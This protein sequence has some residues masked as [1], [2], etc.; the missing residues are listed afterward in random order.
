MSILVLVES[1]TKCGKIEEYLGDDYKC[2]ATFGHL[3]TLNHLDDINTKDFSI[4]FTIDETKRKQINKIKEAIQSCKD[5]IIAT[6]GDREGEGIAWHICM[7]FH[8]PLST[9]KRVVFNEITKK[10]INESFQNIKTIDMNLVYAQQARQIIDI[11]VGFSLSPLLWKHV[12][13]SK[14]G[15]SAGRCQTPALKIIYDNQKEIDHSSGEF[16]YNTVGYF[17]SLNIPYHLNISFKDS[18]EIKTFLDNCKTEKYMLHNKESKMIFKKS[19]N[20]FTTSSLQQRCCKEMR[21]SPKETMTICQ[22]L[23]E[24]GYITYM[25]TDSETYSQEFIESTCQ[26]IEKHYGENLIH[27]N[28]KSNSH[29]NSSIKSAHEAIRPTDIQKADYTN[30]TVKENRLYKIIWLNACQS[31][32][33]DSIYSQ[34]LSTITMSS[35]SY[36]F[37]YNAE[38][39]ITP[40]WEML[41][42][43]SDVD[44]KYYGFLKTLSSVTLTSCNKIT[45]KIFLSHSKNHLDEGTLVQQLEKHGI[46]RPSTFS[47]IVDKLIEKK[48]V[49][50]KDIVGKDF[51]CHDFELVDAKLNEVQSIRSFGADARKLIIQPIG[52]EIIDFLF[53]HFS[54]FTNIEFSRDI[55]KQLDDIAHEKNDLYSLCDFCFSTLT[56]LIENMEEE[57]EVKKEKT[58]NNNNN[59]NRLIG[60]NKDHREVYVKNGKYGPYVE[61]DQVKSKIQQNDYDTITIE[62]ALRILYPDTERKHDTFELS[63]TCSIRKGKYGFY[64]YI[65]TK[66]MKKPL[67]HSLIGYKE[68]KDQNEVE[69]LFASE[70]SIDNKELIQWIWE[71]YS[72]HP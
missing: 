51:C 46:G 24:Y 20:P 61:C 54:S 25:R 36:E 13:K 16:L 39:C 12:G 3:R 55:E 64:L 1:P 27:L 35:S 5:V 59:K 34:I 19:P 14:Q 31:I 48:Y 37:Q 62:N 2:I 22:T 23:Y 60:F 40:G 41:C 10:S 57:I 66:Q 58:N 45:S 52:N 68:T 15:L 72:L 38:T 65:K 26:Y 33:I 4:T 21:I 8:L 30:L 50:K 44:N 18:S 9:T 32:M 7:L 67:F 42:K 47:S 69:T 53:A 6:D 70:N 28:Y 49:I 56:T 17:T 71:R 43:K 63:K 29:I 11:I